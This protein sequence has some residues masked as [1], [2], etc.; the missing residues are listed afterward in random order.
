M[1]IALPTVIITQLPSYNSRWL[2]EETESSR[3]TPARLDGNPQL[4]QSPVS[5]P[6]QHPVAHSE[7]GCN[8]N[9]DCPHLAITALV[10][11]IGRHGAGT[12]DDNPGSSRIFSSP[13][14]SIVPPVRASPQQEV[15]Y[16]NMQGLRRQQAAESIPNN[17]LTRSPVRTYIYV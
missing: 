5:P 17:F 6:A 9:S 12:T 1:W 7:T 16:D 10:P 13:G 11:E 14:S 15:G 4:R 8:S 3:C 2:D